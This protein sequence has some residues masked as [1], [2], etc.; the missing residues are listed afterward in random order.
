[1]LITAPEKLKTKVGDINVPITKE[2][3][4]ARNMAI[5]SAYR[6]PRVT[7]AVNVSI[8]AN[9]RRRPGMG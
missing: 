9:P 8:L 5:S 3:K 4:M 2:L 1:V 6:K 7:N